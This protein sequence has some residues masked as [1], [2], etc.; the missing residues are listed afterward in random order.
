MMSLG[1]VETFFNGHHSK[2]YIVPQ[3]SSCLRLIHIAEEVR[4][5]VVV[6]KY[7]WSGLCLFLITQREMI[8]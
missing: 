3:G 8:G 2:T 1:P 5:W 7:F 6:F 4:L